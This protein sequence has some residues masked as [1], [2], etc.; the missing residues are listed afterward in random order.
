MH[1]DRPSCIALETRL[2]TPRDH[3]AHWLKFYECHLT[4]VNFF[5]ACPSDGYFRN[6]YLIYFPD[7][8]RLV[9]IFNNRS[10]YDSIR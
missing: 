9:D 8:V 7:K 3:A 4:C 10:R 1:S 2:K 6:G 5:I